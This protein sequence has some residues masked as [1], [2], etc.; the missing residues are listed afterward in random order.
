[1]KQKQ[2]KKEK[3]TDNKQ[4]S[5]DVTLKTAPS[6]T[7]PCD[8][9]GKRAEAPQTSESI[10]NELV[11]NEVASSPKPT[12]GQVAPTGSAKKLDKKQVQPKKA[13]VKKDSSSKAEEKKSSEAKVTKP[14]AKKRETKAA[15]KTE[16][17]TT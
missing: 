12:E 7:K 2:L 1:M 10:L 13:P 3:S 11:S 16:K 9:P 17:K 8:E 15:E 5:L 6:L 4:M 14:V